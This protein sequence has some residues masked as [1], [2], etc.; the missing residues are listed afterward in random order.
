MD[1]LKQFLAARLLAGRLLKD[2]I[3]RNITCCGT[4]IGYVKLN[5]SMQHTCRH[6]QTKNY[7]ISGNQTSNKVSLS[8]IKL[9]YLI[10]K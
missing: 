10:Y 6:V 9:F 7:L 2:Y 8:I 4:F 1:K 3:N 5:M